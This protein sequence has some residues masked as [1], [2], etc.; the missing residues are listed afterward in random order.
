VQAET[1]DLKIKNVMCHS[2]QRIHKITECFM[3]LAR[4]VSTD[5]RRVAPRTAVDADDEP[6]SN[7]VVG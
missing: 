4:G 6:A 1:T 5:F 3:R 7:E 2:Q